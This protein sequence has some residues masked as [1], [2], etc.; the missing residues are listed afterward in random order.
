MKV[1]AWSKTIENGKQMTGLQ[2]LFIKESQ[3]MLDLY[4]EQR[5]DMV[6]NKNVLQKFL[7]IIIQ[8]EL[9]IERT[10]RK[11]FNYIQEEPS[12]AYLTKIPIQ[13]YAFRQSNVH[14]I[15]NKSGKFYS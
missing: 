4:N 12:L 9:E 14:K 11:L 6:Q 2:S 3:N 8:Q 13:K 5:I 1:K 7:H 10:R 15:I